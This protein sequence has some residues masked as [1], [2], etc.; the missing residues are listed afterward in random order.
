MRER[1]AETGAAPFKD[2]HI[3]RLLSYDWRAKTV[4]EH[5]IVRDRPLES[6]VRQLP[7]HRQIVAATTLLLQ[8]LDVIALAGL[9]RDRSGLLVGFF[10]P[11][12]GRSPCVNRR[13]LDLVSRLIVCAQVKSAI[14]VARNPEN[15]A[16]GGRRYEQR[17]HS[18]AITVRNIRRSLENRLDR[19]VRRIVR[20]IWAAGQVANSVAADVQIDLAQNAV[21]C[22]AEDRNGKQSENRARG[23]NDRAA[24]VQILHD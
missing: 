22:L 20:K 1:H 19:F 11:F 15:V 6:R 3:G 17:A 12:A 23:S 13:D 8:R 4:N 7:A 5:A 18:L 21:A 9:K 24:S 10:G 14:I 2:R 16:A